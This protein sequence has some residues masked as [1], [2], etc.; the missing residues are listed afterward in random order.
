MDDIGDD[1]GLDTPIASMLPIMA[2]VGST[3]L[4]DVIG[5]L[6]LARS[7]PRILPTGPW[8]IC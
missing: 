6:G 2:T 8:V 3:D 1:D 5:T 4:N 7:T